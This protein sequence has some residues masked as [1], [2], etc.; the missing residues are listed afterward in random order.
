VRKNVSALVALLFLVGLFGAGTLSAADDNYDQL[1]TQEA[2]AVGLHG[3]LLGQARSTLKPAESLQVLKDRGIIPGSWDGSGNVTM[4]ETQEV[5]SR[6]GVQISVGDPEA[7]LSIGVFERLLHKALGTFQLDRQHWRVQH[8]FSTDLT[9][10]QYRQ[11]VI[12][13]SGF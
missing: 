1:V 9:L 10:G 11:R 5:F 13:G 12:S 2:F 6:L 3:A 8:G 4:G 7:L